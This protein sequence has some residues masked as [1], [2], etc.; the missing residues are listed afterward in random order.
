[1]TNRPLAVSVRAL[2][3]F[4]VFPPDI[5]PLSPSLMN[6]GREAH[7][8]RQQETGGQAETML[9]WEGEVEGLALRVS[10]RMDLYFDQADPPLIEEIKLS[11]QAVPQAPLPEHLL[12]AVCYG[13]MLCQ[14]DRLHEV[15]IRVCY[16]RTTGQVTAD[17]VER[18]D[19]GRLKEAFFGL[20]LPYVS[21]QKQLLSHIANRNN[22]LLNLPFPYPA[23][24]AGQREMAA[25][26]YTA[27]QRRQRLFAVM[28]TGTGKSA[29]AL[30]PALKALGQGLTRQVFCL[31][32]RGTQRLAMQ[33]EVDRMLGQGLRAH[34]LTL[35]AK[36][37]L[38]PMEQMRCH[39]EHCPRA[40]GHYL[41]Q[42][43][44]LVEALEAPIWD[45]AYIQKAA[46]AHS[47]CP[48]EF[49]LALCEIADVVICDYNYAFDPQVRLSRIFDANR[50]LTLLVDEAHN[51]PDRARDMLSGSITL[52]RLADFRREAGKL[53]GRTSP[54]YKALTACIKALRE[55]GDTGDG[56]PVL[57]ALDPVLEAL[58]TQYTPG[59]MH[60]L[61]DLVSLKSALQKALALADDYAL[62]L[63]AQGSR[64]GVTALNLNPAPHLG[65]VT[66]RLSG[67][68]YYSATLSPLTAMRSLLGG[69]LEDACLAL[70]SP[71][72][73]EH[74]LTLQ[75]GLNT[76]YAA[77]ER[78]LKPAAE[79]ILA[80]F[81]ARP[82]K[83][84]A[85]FPSFA[86]LQA[87]EQ[88]MRELAPDLPYNVQQ[89]GMDEA[90]RLA[91]LATFVADDGPV[92]GL[93][94]LGG[95]FSEGVDL[96][97][98]ALSAVAIL[99]VGL[100]QVNQQNNLYRARMEEAM[101]DGFAFAY[102][103]PGM[104]KVLQAAGRLIRS[105]TDRG[106][107]LLLDDRYT[108]RDY[109]ELLPEH[110]TLFRVSST[111]E[112]TK[113]AQAFFDDAQ[114]GWDLIG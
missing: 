86:Y 91:F 52:S 66:R 56:A 65:E 81:A 23:Y 31:T 11:P 89:P 46:D 22:S 70:P 87:V 15:D 5:L 45:G 83:M 25:Q 29:A 101:G 19:Q 17:F 2:V 64:G 37:S 27:I 33:Q 40:A 53:H 32:A 93:C 36:E 20:L 82:G 71:F 6:L 105:E 113:A 42:Q 41:R 43:A 62:I 24:R 9:M 96:P 38:C 49:S 112:I 80:L 59:V 47:L 67:V 75:M 98:K 68:V 44:A 111:Q 95:V 88:V 100:P 94:V 34:A 63:D 78:S 110:I 104:H 74:L 79:A 18:W 114:K 85:Y 12:Q 3:G 99:G 84:I 77:R 16:A 90:S 14:R 26:V 73:P 50:R 8:A 92:L 58:S 30:Y 107:L 97:G 10:G 4:S 1:M 48:F 7:V 103:Y 109:R 72:P 61:R 69:D 21:W 39:P 35:N 76:R 54:V 28:P 106:V 55:A 102:R 60:L 51:L 57:D 13:F 108:Q